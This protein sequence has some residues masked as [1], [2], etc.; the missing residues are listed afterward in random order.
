MSQ[1]LRLAQ[2][3][4]ECLTFTPG[5]WSAS[6]RLTAAFKDWCRDN[7]VEGSLQDLRER[8]RLEGCEPGKWKQ[9]RGW[10]NVGLVESRFR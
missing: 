5:A 7:G 2:F 9:Q 8:L 1:V 6:G 4:E 10:W 3:V